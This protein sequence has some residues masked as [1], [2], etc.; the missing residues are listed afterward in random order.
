MF[1]VK[2]AL[3]KSKNG[4]K[5]KIIA[6]GLT[7]VLILTFAGCTGMQ[8]DKTRKTDANQKDLTGEAIPVGKT[9][10]TKKKA[11]ADGK[12]HQV[13]AVVTKVITNQN[14]VNRLI[15]K[16]NA[17]GRSTQIAAADGDD[18]HYIAARYQVKFSESFPSGDFGVTHTTLHFRVVNT[19]GGKTFRIGG[20]DYTGLNK[21]YEIG[22]VPMGYDFY[23]PATYKG[24][25]IYQMVKGCDDYLLEEYYRS[26]KKTIK[27]YIN[28]NKKSRN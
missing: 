20:T 1:H 15:K 13:T 9:F 17:S 24:T 27:H 16:Y 10:K 4:Q 6:I 22:S 19:G 23:P 18:V 5:W 11:E 7:A 28:P 3:T 21:T 26:G 8:E 2:Q 25:I 12:L 14:T